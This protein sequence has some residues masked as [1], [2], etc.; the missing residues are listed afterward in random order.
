MCHDLETQELRAP[1]AL[2]VHRH[3]HDFVRRG[4]H[5]NGRNANDKHSGLERQAEVE[6]ERE[7]EKERKREIE[8]E[9]ETGKERKRDLSLL[10]RD[11]TGSVCSASFVVMPMLKCSPLPDELMSICASCREKLEHIFSDP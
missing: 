3:A 8:S 7:R 9:G 10:N 4:M 2:L 5:S 1:L 6:R 11:A